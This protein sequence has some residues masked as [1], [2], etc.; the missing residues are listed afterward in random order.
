MSCFIFISVDNSVNVHIVGI[1]IGEILQA[2]EC[3]G[4]RPLTNTF[5]TEIE[6]KCVL[7]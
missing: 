3:F 1:T 2:L 4:L 5:N 6:A 7:L